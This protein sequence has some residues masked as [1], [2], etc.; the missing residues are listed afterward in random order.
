WAR[1]ARPGAV[2]AEITYNHHAR[3]ANAGI[4]PSIFGLEIEMPGEKASPG[5]TAIPLN[6]LR[7]RYDTAAKRFVLRSVTLGKEIVPVISSGVNPV[8]I[9]S[10]L[11]TVGFQGLQ[12]IG[13]FPGLD[14]PGVTHWPRVALGNLVLFPDR[15]VVRPGEWPLTPR[16]DAPPG[17]GSPKPDEDFFI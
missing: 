17:G 11:V 6:D 13:F 16:G 5:A 12:P 9:T 2:L 3:T 7:V 8:G 14:A 10:F 4:R 1:L 15:W